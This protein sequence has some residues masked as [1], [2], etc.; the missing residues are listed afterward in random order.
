MEII[1]S[2]VNIGDILYEYT[3]IN[4]NQSTIPLEKRTY[5]LDL[6]KDMKNK[7]AIVKSEYLSPS[8]DLITKPIKLIINNAISNWWFAI[9]HLTESSEQEIKFNPALEIQ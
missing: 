9:N 4:W 2:F 8:F 3:W 1:F 5:L 7:M 6:I